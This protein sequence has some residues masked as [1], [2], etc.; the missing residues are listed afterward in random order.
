MLIIPK[1]VGV[2]GFVILAVCWA[3]VTHFFGQTEGVRVWGLG[4]LVASAY[5]ACLERIP[6]GIRGL[7]PS[8]YLSG[9][10]KAFAIL[11]TGI[12]GALVATFPHEVACMVNLRGY[13]CI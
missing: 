7:E 2:F 10:R 3:A 6:V 8:L 9:A 5:M 11:P 1:P 4:L 13:S 12:I